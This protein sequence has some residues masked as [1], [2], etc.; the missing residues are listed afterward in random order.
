MIRRRYKFDKPSPQR[1]RL[2]QIFSGQVAKAKVEDDECE[3]ETLEEEE[4][5]DEDDALLDRLHEYA[6]VVMTIRPDITKEEA[7]SWLVHNAH[8]RSAATHMA[9]IDK[10]GASSMPTFDSY[11]KILKDNGGSLTQICKNITEAG[12]SSGITGHQLFKL[13][14]IE[15]GKIRKS[16]ETSAQA[17]SR[18]FQS[19]EALPLRKAMLVCKGMAYG[20]AR[21]HGF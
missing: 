19:D 2:M 7:L 16:G 8:G 10:Q 17:F 15:A 3:E 18:F 20:S 11:E 14:E 1:K 4:Q 13:A 12:D 6:D 21:T 5:P 9:S